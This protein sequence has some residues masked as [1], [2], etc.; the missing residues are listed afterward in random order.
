MACHVPAPCAYLPICETGV[1]SEL[2]YEQKPKGKGGDK[3]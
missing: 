3:K 2:I 1:V